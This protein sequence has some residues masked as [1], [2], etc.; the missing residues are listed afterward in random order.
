[1]PPAQLLAYLDALGQ[2]RDARRAEL[3]EL[4]RAALDSSE[5]DELSPDLVLS[6]AIWKS[7]SDRYDLLLVTWDS[8]RIGARESERLS[9]LIWGG[10]D[11]GSGA[12]GTLAVSLPEACALSDALAGSLRVRLAV[13]PDHADIAARLRD[14]RAQVERIRDLVDREPATARAAA[15]QALDDLDHRVEQTAERDRRGA[16]VGGLLGPLEIQAARCERDLIVGASARRERAADL[17]RARALRT[18]LEAEGVAVR[19]LADRCV[20]Q[21]TPAP[22][23]AVPDVT[24]LG[25]VPNTPDA[26]AAYLAR[27]DT[28]RRALGQAHSA[29]GTALQ[30]RDELAGRLDA[31]HVKAGDTPSPDL[32]E[33]YR[34]G[35]EVLGLL[36]V[37]LVRLGALTIAYQAYL[38]ASLAAPTGPRR[39]TEGVS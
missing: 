13:D 8:G 27:L 16:D 12:A 32:D 31:Y 2:W 34:R 23:L 11:T 18:E 14:L 7:V 24:A 22:H 19:A 3:D 33:L 17:A 36:P 20:A 35:R 39:A 9:T 38:E 29:Y 26:L 28:V 37:D 5:E 10:L 4:D 1:M 21:V 30:R 15:A 25:P 6:M